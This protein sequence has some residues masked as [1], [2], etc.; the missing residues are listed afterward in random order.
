MRSFARERV[1]TGG[2][3][4]A[5]SHRRSFVGG[6]LRHALRSPWHF[7]VYV[8][9]DEEGHAI[10]PEWWRPLAVRASLSIEESSSDDPKTLVP[11]DITDLLGRVFPGLPLEPDESALGGEVGRRAPQLFPV[12]M[13]LGPYRLVCDPPGQFMMAA[14]RFELVS[15]SDPFERLVYSVF[16]LYAFFTLVTS[17]EAYRLLGRAGRDGHRRLSWRLD[18]AGDNLSGFVPRLVSIGP[19]PAEPNAGRRRMDMAG[20][21]VRGHN[22][23]RFRGS[24]R[25]ICQ[26]RLNPDPFSPVEY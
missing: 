11:M 24:P 22:L 14:K 8:P 3:I 6:S 15:E 13:A 17:G 1:T 16:P 7:A 26:R 9:W 4:V 21:Y 20:F 25:R 18:V 23:T 10:M 5:R 2:A 19:H 12:A